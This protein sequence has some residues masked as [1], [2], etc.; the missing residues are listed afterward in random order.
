MTIIGI[1][2]THDGTLSVIR[3]GKHIFSIAEE[4]INRVKCHIGFP[5]SS[6]RYVVE[7][8]IVKPNEVSAVAVAS[9]VFKKEWARSF[10]LELVEDKK[11]YDFQNDKPPKDFY[12][13]D[14]EWE[15]VSSDEE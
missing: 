2:F 4:R 9:G 5:F 13:N 8:G 3:D 10:A 12:I 6:L 14:P 11:Y 15:K 1:T 7:R